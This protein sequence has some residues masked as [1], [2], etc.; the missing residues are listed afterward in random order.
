MLNLWRS[1][2]CTSTCGANHG[3]PD[4][5]DDDDDD[6]D[7]DRASAEEELGRRK[8]LQVIRPRCYD[9]ATPDPCSPFELATGPQG[10]ES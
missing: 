2:W 1:L 3:A 8:Q 9:G 4:G 5:D 10:V 7:D 6:D